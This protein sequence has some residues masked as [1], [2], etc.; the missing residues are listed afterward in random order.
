MRR[1]QMENDTILKALSSLEIANIFLE[2][3]V[4]YDR[5]ATMTVYAVFDLCGGRLSFISRRGG[6]EVH[7]KTQ[8]Q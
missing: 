3:T 6:S 7:S 8:V 2:R 5:K 1:R 4:Y